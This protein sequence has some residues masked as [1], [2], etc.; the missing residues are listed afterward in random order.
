M[1]RMEV[2]PERSSGMV[3]NN[4]PQTSTS[5]VTTN[6]MVPNGATIVIGGLMENEDISFQAGVPGLSKL[7]WIGAL[8]RRKREQKTRTEL[9]VLLTPHIWNPSAPPETNP[10]YERLEE[11]K[12]GAGPPASSLP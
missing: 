8:F 6:V 5:E 11:S 2:H 7:P 9:I 10:L 4:I 1:I 12:R 3:V